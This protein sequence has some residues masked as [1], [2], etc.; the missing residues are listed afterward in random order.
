[1]GCIF[2]IQACRYTY[3]HD[4]TIQD[5]SGCA[6]NKSVSQAQSIKYPSTR[7]G[8][9][10]YIGREARGTREQTPP[11]HLEGESADAMQNA[12]C[13]VQTAGAVAGAGADTDTDVDTDTDTDTNKMQMQ[14]QV[15]FPARAWR[16]PDELS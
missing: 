2:Y 16:R 10:R 1:M 8:G 7:L 9:Q 14:V 3:T 6:V 15:Q 12:D 4:C 11:E 5:P 13:R